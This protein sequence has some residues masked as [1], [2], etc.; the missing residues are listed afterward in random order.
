MADAVAG[1]HDADAGEGLLGPLEERVALAVALELD[2]HVLAQRVGRVVHVDD[3]GVIHDEIDRHQ[4]LDAR[5]VEFLALRFGAHGGEI[6]QRGEARHVLQHDAREHER[7]L[8]RCAGRSASSR[9]ARR[10]ASSVMRLPSQ[11]RSTDSSTT[12]RL[13]GMRETLPRPASSSAASE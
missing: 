5:R 8:P 13:T 4:R 11:L 1:R 7:Q 6:V 12:R 9:R 3:D 2:F 10:T